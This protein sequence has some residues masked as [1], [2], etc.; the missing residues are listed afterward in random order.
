M[1]SDQTGEEEQ[2]GESRSSSISIKESG[3]LVIGCIESIKDPIT[4]SSLTV[5][6]TQ[7]RN[8]VVFMTTGLVTTH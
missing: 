4:L 3:H 6:S 1:I 8:S 2:E 7:Y 5:H